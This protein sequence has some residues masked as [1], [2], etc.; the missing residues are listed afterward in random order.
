MNSHLLENGYLNIWKPFLI[1]NAD[2]KHSR[3][4]GGC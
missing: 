1:P 4:R 3:V 2:E